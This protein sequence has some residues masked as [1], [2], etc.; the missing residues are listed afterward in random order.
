MKQSARW[1][2]V[3]TAVFVLAGAGF[4]Y[5]R[6]RPGAEAP[7]PRQR[8]PGIAVLFALRTLDREPATRL[9]GEQI[10][11][12]L[13]FVKALKD[14]PTSDAAAATA[15]ARAVRDVFTPAQVAALEE[16]RRRFQDRQ[17]EGGGASGVGGGVGGGEGGGVG[18]AGSGA[19]P[20]GQR[21]GQI[22]DEQRN[23]FRRRAFERMI[24]SLERRMKS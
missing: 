11:K 1:I 20:G 14:V 17:R 12:I 7:T 13:P 21:T 15:I 8:D 18:A 10:A 6:G 19:A 3:A 22:S 4:Y 24:R 5:A 2:A 16:A 23:E 9:T